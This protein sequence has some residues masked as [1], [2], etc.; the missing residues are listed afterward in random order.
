M[1]EAV[2]LAASIFAVISF[3]GKV[4]Q[5]CQAAKAIFDGVE[6]APKHVQA[7]LTELDLIKN[8]AGVVSGLY[9]RLDAA[10]IDFDVTP[11]LQ[12]CNDAIKGLR[13]RIEGAHEILEARDG[14]KISRGRQRL[15][16]ILGKK[17]IRES[18]DLLYRARLQLLFAQ[19]NL[20]L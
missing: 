18:V 7:L 6:D 5:G 10:G 8:S 14:H 9:N 19:S 12:L 20:M 1:A 13:R 16:F 2:G 17:T 11:A 3:A 15:K 4:I